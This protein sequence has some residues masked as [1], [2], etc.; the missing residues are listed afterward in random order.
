MEQSNETGQDG[1]NTDNFRKTIDKTW[2]TVGGIVQ[3]NWI[4]L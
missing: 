2:L 1:S 4:L 3:W